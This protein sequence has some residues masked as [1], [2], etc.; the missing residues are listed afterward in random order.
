MLLFSRE[1]SCRWMLEALDLGRTRDMYD[2]WGYVVMPEHVHLVLW[3]HREVRIASILKTLKQ[4][5]SKRALLW[6]EANEP[7]FLRRLENPRPNGQRSYRFW[8]RG[9]GYDRNL[10]SVEDVHQ[11]IEYAH[12]NPVRR[13]LVEKA[14]LWPWSSFHAWATGEND[15]IAIDR[16]TMPAMMP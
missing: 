11:K 9:G 13:G 16:E 15:P 4:S 8:Q 7:S 3:P 5:V 1:R 14:S 6:L 2:L 12:N 10:R